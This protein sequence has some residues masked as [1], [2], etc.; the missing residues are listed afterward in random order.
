MEFEQVINN[1]GKVVIAMREK[2]R[3]EVRDEV[4]VCKATM[5]YARACECDFFVLIWEIG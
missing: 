4:C 1:Q 3:Q 5:T 2:K